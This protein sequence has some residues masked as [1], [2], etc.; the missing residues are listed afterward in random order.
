M[1]VLLTGHTGFK[2][3]WMTE[4]LCWHGHEVS[5]L[6]LDPEPG[7]LFARAG[8]MGH[9]TADVR[10]DVRDRA[11][12]ASWVADLAP[13]A[14]VHLAAQPL[15]RRSY[16]EPVL[17][18]DTN[19]M[20]TLAVLEAVSGTPSVRACVVVTTDKVYRNDGRL[21]GYVETD[22]L[23]GRDP[24]SASKAMADVLAA[25]WAE[26]VSSPAVGIARAGNVIGGGDVSL[27]RLLPDV[28]AAFSRGE[29]AQIRYPEAVRP[30][31]HVLD[32]LEG[33]RLLLEALTT[34]NGAGAWN[35]GPDPSGVRTV[36]EVVDRAAALW[37]EGASWVP[38][39]GI[40]P[41]EEVILTLDASRARKNLSWRD[42][43]SFED[44]VR[45]TVEWT[46][47]VADGEDA[48]S[49]TREQ[50]DAFARATMES[51]S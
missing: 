47:R 37:G 41:H 29:P 13:D 31:Q 40:H 45:W 15:V 25:S 11:A 33:Y 3:A 4:L 23:G 7:S 48:L 44:A 24:Y 17:T 27:D 30:W 10:C 2:G 19:V 16:A 9:L 22:P 51:S 20:G 12:V 34:G 14:V 32:C 43:L 50:V 42:H 39:S 8:L 18:F 36:K 28:L 26:S 21:S 46:R 35:F 1:R 38:Q 5:G 6:A 49:V